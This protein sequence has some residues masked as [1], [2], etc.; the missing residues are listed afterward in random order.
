MTSP[1]SAEYK[2]RWDVGGGCVVEGVIPADDL[3]AAQRALPGR[4]PTAEE[5]ADGV[6]PRR[7][8]FTAGRRPSS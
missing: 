8:P 6:D 5:F 7:T 3:A 1:A 2:R 4:F